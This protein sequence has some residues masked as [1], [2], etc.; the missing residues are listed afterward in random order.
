MLRF[1][2]ILRCAGSVALSPSPGHVVSHRPAFAGAPT[3]PSFLAPRAAMVC[4][5]TRE[6][7]NPFILHFQRYA[8]R[9]ERRVVLAYEDWHMNILLES[10]QFELW[11]RSGANKKGAVPLGHTKDDWENWEATAFNRGRLKALAKRF[12][13]ESDADTCQRLTKSEEL[14]YEMIATNRR[15]HQLQ[16]ESYELRMQRKFQ[17]AEQ[18]MKEARLA[19]LQLIEQLAQLDGKQEEAWD[20]LD[21]YFDRPKGT[22]AHLERSFAA[23][24]PAT[25]TAPI[26]WPDLTE[27]AVYCTAVVFCISFFGCVYYYFYFEWIGYSGQAEGP[28][29]SDLAWLQFVQYLVLGS[30]LLPFVQSLVVGAGLTTNADPPLTLAQRLQ[31]APTVLASILVVYAYSSWL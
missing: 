4:M 29:E 30:L 20:L 17:A 12:P 1:A 15:C 26:A 24:T 13:H 9:L 21:V 23:S 2:L 14:L 6:A 27:L 5:A 25:A 18:K 28:T 3:K 7:E 16:D 11:H 31:R 8:S 10:V 19:K 22:T